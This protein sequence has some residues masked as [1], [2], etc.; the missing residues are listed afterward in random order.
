M[1][2]TTLSTSPATG[3]NGGEARGAEAVAGDEAEHLEV[4]EGRGD[5]LEALVGD[6]H[7]L[8]A[9]LLEQ[10][11]PVGGG[12]DPRRRGGAPGGGD[13]AEVGEVGLALDLGG[14]HGREPLDGVPR[15]GGVAVGDGEAAARPALGAEPRAARPR[16]GAPVRG[17]G[18]EGEGVLPDLVR[19]RVP[20]RRRGGARRARAAAPHAATDRAGGRLWLFCA[21]LPGGAARRAR[22]RRRRHLLRLC[23]RLGLVG[24]VKPPLLL[25]SLLLSL[26]YY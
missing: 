16:R 14:A 21:E 25:S 23:S 9:E 11:P 3:S 12:G 13:E 17:G 24:K 6:D 18:E 1:T 8:E 19:E 26:L 22:R 10:R 15:R 7:A 5:H 2:Q 4:P 20:R